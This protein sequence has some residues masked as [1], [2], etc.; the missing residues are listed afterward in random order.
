MINN[1]IGEKIKQYRKSLN[2][3]RDELANKIG[4][5]VHAIAKYEQNQRKP[6]LD[7]IKKISTALSIP[8]NRLII[9]ENDLDTSTNNYTNLKEFDSVVKT[10]D[11]YSAKLI[12]NN[13]SK[14][15]NINNISI[16]ELSEKINCSENEIINYENGTKMPRIE[17]LKKIAL[18]TYTNI[19]D[20]FGFPL[21]EIKIDNQ[22]IL[23]RNP[24]TGYI[25]N[26]FLIDFINKDID[27]D[28]T[29]VSHYIDKSEFDLVIHILEN[30]GYD[31]NTDYKTKFEITDNVDTIKPINLNFSD[32]K[33]FSKNLN[34]VI[35]GLVENFIQKNSNGLIEN[36][37]EEY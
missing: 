4:C 1:T 19:E 34:W 16:K 25:I 28:N 32:F 27:I 17:I 7:I 23:Y 18:A 13:I 21:E 20:L 2:L 6:N 15:R 10:F 8:I 24:Q 11:N 9:E 3:S 31:I 35:N 29:P 33:N 22:T 30:Y 12:G 5:S 36:E 37:D 26:D 14:F